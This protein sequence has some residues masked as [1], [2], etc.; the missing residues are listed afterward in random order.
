MNF[1][2]S[3]FKISLSYPV[4]VLALA[5]TFV[6]GCGRGEQDEPAPPPADPVTEA[7]IAGVPADPV[8]LTQFL[9]AFETAEPSLKLYSEETVMVI[10]GR[11]FA[12]AIEQ[13]QKLSRNPSLTPAQRAAIAD[14]SQKLQALLGRRYA[15]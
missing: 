12:D 6:T 11:A 10:R 8:D 9:K 4:V 14:V 13:L 5:V 7:A 15:G 1:H 3:Q 2:I